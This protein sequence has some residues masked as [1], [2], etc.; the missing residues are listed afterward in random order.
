MLSDTKAYAV[1]NSNEFIRLPSTPGCTTRRLSCR[2]HET[3]T[4]ES[5]YATYEPTPHCPNI[6][7]SLPILMAA[8]KALIG[9]GVLPEIVRELVLCQ[10]RARVS[11]RVDRI[12]LTTRKK[13]QILA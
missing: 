11:A 7:M 1:T 3:S 9:L 10:L 12:G 8:M 6:G 5:K 2:P 13:R 4:S